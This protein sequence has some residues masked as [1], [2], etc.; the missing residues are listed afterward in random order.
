MIWFLIFIVIIVALGIRIYACVQKSKESGDT[1][2]L[3]DKYAANDFG[4]YKRHVNI[5]T[6]ETR[7]VKQM[8]TP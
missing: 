1:W 3:K 6:I 4:E 7:I 8:K 2:N 5:G